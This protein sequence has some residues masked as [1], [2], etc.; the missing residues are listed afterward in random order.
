[1]EKRNALHAELWHTGKIFVNTGGLHPAA[2][3][4]RMV[5]SIPD[6]KADLD[7]ETL[8]RTLSRTLVQRS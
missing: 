1:M 3:L 5:S 6:K 7:G 4:F 2:S 8:S